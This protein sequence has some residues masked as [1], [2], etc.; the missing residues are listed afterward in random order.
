M[1][2]T[3]KV[4]RSGNWWAIEVPEIPGL[5]TQARR[6]DQVA[7]MVQ[8][9]ASLAGL[10]DVDVAVVPVLDDETILS[11][12]DAKRCRTTLA[13]ATTAAAAASREAVAKLRSQ[14]LP[15]RDVAQLLGIS[16]QRI[17]AL[18]A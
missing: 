16:P 6:L 13:V 2:V 18:A 1:N 4:V 11:I 7:A 3:A 12:E 17:S 14:G 5:F 10:G 9:A 8:D 15:V